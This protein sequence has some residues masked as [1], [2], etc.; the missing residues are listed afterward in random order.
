[1]RRPIIYEDEKQQRTRIKRR[2]AALKS[3]E[4]RRNRLVAKRE[5]AEK[6]SRAPG[7]DA[8]FPERSQ[9]F[10][11]DVVRDPGVER[12]CKDTLN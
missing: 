2:A 1:M 6:E 9:P 11:E 3:A 8:S 4:K 7:G 10:P 5:G 12:E